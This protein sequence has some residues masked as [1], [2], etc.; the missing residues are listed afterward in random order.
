MVNL[1]LLL[2]SVLTMGAACAGAL[3]TITSKVGSAWGDS[4]SLVLL[5]LGLLGAA[6]LVQKKSSDLDTQS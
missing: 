4:T 3:Y 2:G 6:H 5:G 1:Y